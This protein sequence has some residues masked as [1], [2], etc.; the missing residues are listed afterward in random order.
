MKSSARRAARAGGFD[1]NCSNS[2]PL[3]SLRRRDYS[4]VDKQVFILS[5]IF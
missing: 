2:V 3:Y 4:N 1:G 5:L